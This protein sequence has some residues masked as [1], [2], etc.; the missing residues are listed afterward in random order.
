MST[1]REILNGLMF[2]GG[3]IALS[4]AQ[5]AEA[6]AAAKENPQAFLTSSEMQ[7]LTEIADAILP[8]TDTPG[9]VDVG[10]PQTID[11]LLATWASANTQGVYR[12]HI[13]TLQT[14]LTK[15]GWGKS[16]AS[17]RSKILAAYDQEAFTQWRS[18]H[19][20]YFA[21]KSLIAQA[22][23]MSEAGATEEL[24][25]EAVPGRWLPSA[26]IE[27]VGRVWAT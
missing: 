9:A 17:A 11:T 13:Q 18:T 14:E 2:L 20:G 24:Q 26:P 12:N 15:R 22:Y 27:E 8:R 5:W 7:C 21:L 1:R 10:V 4:G 3:T 25:Y 6:V 16:S 23:Y 19:A